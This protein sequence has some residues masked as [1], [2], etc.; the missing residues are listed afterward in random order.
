[1]HWNNLGRPHTHLF[2][3]RLQGPI[4]TVRFVNTQPIGTQPGITAW[5]YGTVCTTASQMLHMPLHCFQFCIK[6]GLYEADVP[7]PCMPMCAEVC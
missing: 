7:W 6:H 1:M 3:L 4:E 2:A 5:L